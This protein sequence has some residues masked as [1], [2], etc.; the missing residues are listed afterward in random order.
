MKNLKRSILILIVM[1]LVL[2]FIPVVLYMHHFENSYILVT[3]DS[4]IN[5]ICNHIYR[6]R[7]V[8]YVTLSDGS[9]L[10]L[11]RSSNFQYE[12]PYFSELLMSGDQLIKKGMNDTVYIV[13]PSGTRYLFVYGKSIG[14]RK[15]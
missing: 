1:G 4:E 2:V 14:S 8:S 9:K 7:G 6:D 10:S 5:G 11:K 13:K 15:N 3:N 12:V